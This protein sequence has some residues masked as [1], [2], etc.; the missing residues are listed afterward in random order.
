M[1]L[2][3]NSSVLIWDVEGPP[4]REALFTILWR[5]YETSARADFVSMPQLIEASADS[6]RARYLSWIYTLGEAN[7]GDL[8]LI[9]HLKLR[10]N[11][12]YWWMT[13]LVEKCNFAKSPQIDNAIRLM[14]FAD[15]VTEHHVD[16]IVLVSSNQPLAECMRLLCTRIGVK[17]EW[18]SLALKPAPLFWVRRIFLLLPQKLRELAGLIRYLH[19]RWPL[20]G[21]G[22]KEWRQTDGHL[23]FISYLFNLVPNAAIAGLFESRYWAHLPEDLRLHGAKTNWLHIYVKDTLLPNASKAADAIRQ[24]NKT[25][26]GEQV[27]VTLDTFLSLRVIFKTLT[28]WA[29]IVRIGKRLQ[30]SLDV[31]KADGLELWPLFSKDWQ[32]SL[33]GSVAMFNLLNLNLFESAMKTLPKQRVGV[34]LQ[35]N[36]GWEFAMIHSWKAAGHGR[37]IGSPHSCVRFWDLRYFFDSRSY[38]RTGNNLLPLPDQLALNGDAATEAY[39]AGGYS[40]K[41]MVQVEAL[42][43]LGLECGNDYSKDTKL[44]TNGYLHVLVLG[45]YLPSNTRV[46]MSLLEN[47][48]QYLP[49]G[50]VITVKPHP[51]CPIEPTD[52]PGLVMTVTMEPIFTLLPECDVAY[53]S[54]LTSAAV[55]AYCSGVR[56]V[57][58]LDPNTLNLSPLR[59]RQGALFASTSEELTSAI[60]SCASSRRMR[61]IRQDFFTLD[62][63]LIRW[64]KLLLE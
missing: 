15:W 47:A 31:P 39:K 30:K 21:V 32:Q 51:H 20:R 44:H 34:Y 49:S 12:S 5:S 45:D 61:D 4:K 42:R 14:A 18:Q 29:C 60:I 56:V 13:L 9:D 48:V 55:D 35:E 36:Q 17:F 37:L 25:G 58:V 53:A 40:V 28:D 10:P 33:F 24:F 62:Q 59:G 63:S 3:L 57:S 41:N 1:K 52:Y 27:H 23:S 11:F 22:L 50:T 7:I 43:Y 6:L 38:S 46:Q 16:K 26:R 2:N 8:R 19:D 54:A 64:N